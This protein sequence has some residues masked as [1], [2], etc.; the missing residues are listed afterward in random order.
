MSVGKTLKSRVSYRVRRSSGSVF[1][2]DD[3]SDLGGYDQI[4]RVL[5]GLAEK[6]LL[7]KLGYGL[8]TRTKKSS[9]T[10]KRIPEKSLPDLVPEIMSKLGVETA[11]SLAEREYSTGLSSQVPTGRRIAVRKSRISRKIGYGG[12]YVSYERAT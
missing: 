8:Y 10:G 7:M 5:K 11:P 4:G 6:G 3:F 12:N 2:R 9:L 1:L